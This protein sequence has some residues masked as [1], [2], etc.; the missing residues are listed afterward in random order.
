MI[1]ESGQKEN[2]EV[3]RILIRGVAVNERSISS[4]VSALLRTSSLGTREVPQRS[5]ADTA[6]EICR[7]RS[8]IQQLSTN[9]FL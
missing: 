3:R 2:V 1:G 9:M 8:R 7:N 5:T 4:A 6:L